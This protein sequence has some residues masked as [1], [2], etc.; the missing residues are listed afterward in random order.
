MKTFC[1]QVYGC[2]MNQYEAGIVRTLLLNAG[3]RETNNLEEADVILLLTCAVRQHA[4]QRALGYLAT[5][6]SLRRRR[7]ELVSAVLGCMSQNLQQSLVEQGLCDLVL[8]PD[9][10]RQLPELIAQVRTTGKP[11]VAIA[12]TQECYEGIFAEP[13][14]PVCASITVMR[15]CDNYCS[16]CIVPYTRGRERS[17]SLNQIMAEATRLAEKG[18]KDL[19]LLGQ[20]VLAYQYEGHDF[21]SLL[22]HICTI[23]HLSRIRFLTSH[24]RDLD[25][26]LLQALTRLPRV[27]PALHL[28]VQSGS[29]RILQMMNRGYTREEYL[30]KIALARELLPELGLTT[31]VMVGFPS[32][33]EADFQDTLDLIRQVRFDQAYMFRFS[34]RPGTPA[35]DLQPK[36]SEAEAGRR[37]NILIATQNRI[38]YERNV[39]LLGQTVEVLIEAPAPRGEGMLGRTR[40]NRIVIVSGSVRIGQTVLAQVTGIRGW[41]PLAEVL[42]PNSKPATKEAVCLHLE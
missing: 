36:V 42:T 16:Y 9:Q 22:E 38:T 23:P 26:R 12:Q 39:S 14:H 24:P 27:C 29:N 4:E 7:P 32:E 30:E 33:T 15:G 28:P 8:G 17:K 19:T 31:D 3:Y 41:T 35:A 21:V 10:Y 25:L 1:V 2:Q 13:I 37:L 34:A 20:N 5:L 6:R 40:N 11:L 18:I